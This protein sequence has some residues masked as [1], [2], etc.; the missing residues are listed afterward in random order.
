M[1]K[2]SSTVYLEDMFWDMISQYQEKN[3][4][5]SRNDA[6]AFMLKEWEMFKQGSVINVVEVPNIDNAIRL[7]NQSSTPTEEVKK[8]E[9]IIVEEDKQEEPL[10][11]DPM[12]KSGLSQMFASLEEE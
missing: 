9:E 12:I 6:L 8:D 10:K 11:V 4:L 1:A 2:R 3:N 5:S 7:T